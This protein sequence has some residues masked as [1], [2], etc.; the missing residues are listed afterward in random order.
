[1]LC[2]W[3]VAELFN[4][5]F[6]REVAVQ[7]SNVTCLHTLLNQRQHSKCDSHCILLQLN[8][9]TLREGS[10]FALAFITSCISI[11]IAHCIS[12]FFF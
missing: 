5:L 4:R 11:S 1:M 6:Q 9:E 3:W 10:T 12:L 7:I 2:K 8:I